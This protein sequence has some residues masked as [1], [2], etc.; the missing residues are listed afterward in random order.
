MF[1]VQSQA[2]TGPLQVGTGSGVLS[3]GFV[4]VALAQFLLSVP[5]GPV[6]GDAAVLGPCGPPI[7]GKRTKLEHMSAA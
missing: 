5:G 3:K 1:S 4:E 6:R 2:L 7:L